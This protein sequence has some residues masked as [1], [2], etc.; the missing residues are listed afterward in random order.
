MKRRT[1]LYFGALLGTFGFPWIANAKQ[2][3]TFT[4]FHPAGAR[5]T[6]LATMPLACKPFDRKTV[7]V[8]G[9]GGAGGNMV[10]HMIQMGA[11]GIEFICCNTD[12]QGLLRSSAHVKLQLGSGVGAGGTPSIAIV[13]ALEA[14]SRIEAAL[15]GADMVIIVAAMGGGTGSGA[16]PVVAAIAHEL[17]I[18][19]IAVV[20]KPFAYE[21]LR[22]NHIADVAIA[23]L[24]RQ[25][26]SLVTISHE[27]LISTLGE[28]ES[29]SV[30][31]T[32][33]ASDDAIMQAV[34]SIIGGFNKDKETI[35]FVGF[36]DV[37]DTFTRSGKAMIGW[38]SSTGLDRAIQASRK[39]M[40]FSLVEKFAFHEAHFVLVRITA[41]T[42][43]MMGEV[44]SAMK[45]IGR[46][47][48]A[49]ANL[50]F[51][52]N[53]DDTMEDRMKVSI[54]ATCAAPSSAPM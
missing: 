54:C 9:V 32:F 33:R 40:E 24:S 52:I 20:T 27:N 35:A 34:D 36:V 50:L 43:I 39:A 14:R 5:E 26:D 10:Q 23:G 13:R 16:T 7:K 49:R 42:P 25:V 1:F 37:R 45:E 11:E 2:E 28:G 53:C 22:R 51:E 8:I 46:H 29:V 30:L 18:L 31:D 6:D 12:A 19:T 38:A 41:H 47:A 3:P 44:R 21:G 4:E 15:K 17:G 48:S